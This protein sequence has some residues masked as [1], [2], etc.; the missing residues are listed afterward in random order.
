MRKLLFS[1][2]KDVTDVWG[3]LHRARTSDGRSYREIEEIFT[4]EPGP[5][6]HDTTITTARNGA[7]CW[8]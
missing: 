8:C 6:K 3:K 7:S 4:S 1:D 2:G 5:W